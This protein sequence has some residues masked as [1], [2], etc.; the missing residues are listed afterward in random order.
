MG[1]IGFYIFARFLIYSIMKKNIIKSLIGVSIGAAFLYFTLNNKPLSEIFN[2]LKQAHIIWM[3]VSVL[4][5]VV[6][7][8]L[9][10]FRWKV[11]LESSDANPV[12]YSVIYSLILGY[13]VNSFTPK[14]GEIIRCTSLKKSDKIPTSVSFGTVVSERIYDVLVLLLGLVVIFIIEIDRLGGIMHDLAVGIANLFEKNIYTGIGAM[15]L[16]IAG[17]FLLYRLSKKNKLAAKIKSFLKE[18]LVSLKMSLKMRKYKSF[19]LLTILIWLVL[20]F[21]NYSF[22]MSL[23]ETNSSGIYFAFIVLFVGSVGWVVPSP[24][25][26]GTSNFMILQLFVAFSLSEKAGV[27]LGLLA[28]GV[29]FGVTVGLGSLALIYHLIRQKLQ[30]QEG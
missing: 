25:G 2:S 4:G 16:F 9:R 15:L 18:T 14:F 13:F 27:S 8:F 29:T 11:L 30:V 3:L 5:L 6:T 28:S 19:I 24:S 12:R 10:A 22:L 7:F 23:P 17:L 26:I 21:V 20:T 1:S